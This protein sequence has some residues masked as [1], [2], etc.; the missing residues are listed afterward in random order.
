MRTMTRKSDH[1]V[2]SV[3]GEVRRRLAQYYMEPGRESEL[4]IDLLAGSYVPQFRMPLERAELS[5]V[6][7]PVE[8]PAPVKIRACFDARR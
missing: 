6:A 8:I 7:A 5:P 2:R 4:R 3:A 1:V